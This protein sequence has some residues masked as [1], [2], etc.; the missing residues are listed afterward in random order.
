LRPRRTHNST[1][2]FV[3]EGGNEDNDLWGYYLPD[4]IGQGVLCTVWEPTPE[5]R[6]RIAEGEN[7]RLLVWV[8]RP[9][10]MAMDLTDEPIGRRPE[11]GG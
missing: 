5:E 4:N 11:E 3:L 6:Q 2:I 7:I 9:F 10:P 1:H 8:R